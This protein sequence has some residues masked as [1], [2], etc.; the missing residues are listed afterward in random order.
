VKNLIFQYF[1]PPKNTDSMSGFLK[2]ELDIALEYGNAPKWAKL[3]ASLFKQ[4]ADKHGADHIF[5]TEEF[6]NVPIPQH[7][8]NRVWLDPSFDQYDY[9]LSVDPDIIPVNMS[10][11]IFDLPY[12]DADIAGW[13]IE[14]FKGRKL[15]AIYFSGKEYE[16]YKQLF[17]MFGADMPRS[18]RGTA[19][20]RL[21]NGGVIVW[22]KKARL[23]A[24]ENFI[25]PH[26]WCNL[27]FDNTNKMSRY[28]KE[29]PYLNININKSKLKV[30]E[31]KQEW[32]QVWHGRWQDKYNIPKANFIHY[33]GCLERDAEMYEKW[34][35]LL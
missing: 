26:F 17:G 12:K 23:F 25:S 19:R 8:C 30:F 28:N 21:L 2:H 33:A 15:P 18:Q 3:S 9:V 35:H 1:I 14:N 31:L 29:Q 7:E 24:R 13:P 27:R 6:C 4:Y 10:A 22:S 34:K 11:N 20:F 16:A 32:N 5:A